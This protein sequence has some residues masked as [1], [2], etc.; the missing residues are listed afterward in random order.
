MVFL[1]IELKEK[2]FIL[3]RPV[4]DPQKAVENIGNSVVLKIDYGT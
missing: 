2:I 1:V 4:Q 3:N